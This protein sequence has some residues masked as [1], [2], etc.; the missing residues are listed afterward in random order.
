MC[1]SSSPSTFLFNSV[2]NA[3]LF[4]EVS[5]T[6]LPHTVVLMDEA[7]M[8]MSQRI[9]KYFH[10]PP[11]TFTPIKMMHREPYI[12]NQALLFSSAVR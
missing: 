5:E 1:S 10:L 12:R 7:N 3:L 2:K 11:F 6:Y 9:V 4:E 8:E